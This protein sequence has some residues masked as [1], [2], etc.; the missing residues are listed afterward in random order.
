MRLERLTPEAGAALPLAEGQIRGQLFFAA[1]WEVILALSGDA[2]VPAYINQL[3]QLNLRDFF[4]N[5][6][7]IL[8]IGGATNALSTWAQVNGQQRVG[9]ARAAIFYAIQPVWAVF[10]S[11]LSGVDTLSF[12]EV[13]GGLLIVSGSILL[14]TADGSIRSGD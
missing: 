5:L 8:W 3:P 9:A 4:T 1:L 12:Y 14:A 6:I 11:V 7:G 10:L 2:T 13:I